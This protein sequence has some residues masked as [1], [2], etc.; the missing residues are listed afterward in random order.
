MSE[1][2]GAVEEPVKVDWDQAVAQ[3]KETLG[4]EQAFNADDKAVDVQPDDTETTPIEEPEADEVAE[5]ASTET[6]E[7]E[8][9]L[10]EQDLAKLRESS[11]EMAKLV[12]NL[13]GWRTKLTQQ[14]QSQADERKRVESYMPAIEAFEKDP[15]GVIRALAKEHGVNLAVE[16]PTPEPTLETSIAEA[17]KASLGDELE[18]L[19][20]PLS[21]PIADAIQAVVESVVSSRFEPIQNR[22]NQE[23]ERQSLAEVAEAESKFA[24]K[25]PDYK[26][27]E[28]AMMEEAKKWLFDSEGN[29]R[30]TVLTPFEIM[31]RLYKFVASDKKVAA[32]AHKLIERQ[33]KAAANADTSGSGV[34]PKNVQKTRPKKASFAEA[35]RAA[36]AGE[37][38]AEY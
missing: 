12:D 25:Y 19:A 32:E 21:K 11:P 10:P 22:Y 34:S 29:V 16:E 28:P 14:A 37:R 4:D 13:T 18:V 17:M 35:A 27:Y 33:N 6:T 30:P 3:A 8:E 36:K 2:T 5:Q 7:T 20:D 1:S 24:E 23:N 31:E 38:W 15:G 26:E 9:L